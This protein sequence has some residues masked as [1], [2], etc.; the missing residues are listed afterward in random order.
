[1]KLNEQQLQVVNS[2]A[3]RIVCIA[4]AGA[5][6][7]ATL[8]QRIDRLISDGANPESMLILTFTNAAARE[9]TERFKKN[10]PD[11]TSIPEFRT[12]HAFCYSLLVRD[13]DIRHYMGY[14]DI[15]NIAVEEDIR[16]IWT[17]VHTTCNIRLS[18]KKLYGKREALPPKEQ[19][20]YDVF[21]KAYKKQLC[22][23]NLITF[24]ILCY[25]VGQLFVDDIDLVQGYKQKY[26]YVY[27][28]ESQDTDTAQFA[29]VMSFKDAQLFV[30]GD[31]QQMLYRFRG[32]TNDIIKSL[33]EDNTWELI[34]LPRNYRST[35]PIVDFSNKIFAKKWEG[36]PY[37]LAG[38][39]DKDGVPINFCN[40]FPNRSDRLMKVALEMQQKVNEGKSV[41]I[42]CRTNAK[43]TE[44]RTMF[45]D[46]GVPVKGKADNSE[47]V[48]L[49]KSVLD[50][51]YCV[52]WIA[53]MLPNEEYARYLRFST[54]DPSVNE[55]QKFLQM[56]GTKYVR[57]LDKLYHCRS[58]LSDNLLP[59]ELIRGML[60]Y[61]KL[62]IEL[63]PEKLISASLQECMD[64][65]VDKVEASVDKGIY[66]GTIHS[67]KGLEYDI[68][69]VVDVDGDSFNTMKNEDEMACFY[70]A[71]T[72]AKEELYLWYDTT[73][74]DELLQELSAEMHEEVVSGTYY[75][76]KN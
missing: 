72:R 37:Y 61:L 10:H 47:L 28:D 38:Q 70:V 60:R 52:K 14:S 13:T 29:F 48:G 71:C 41:A 7:T 42:L 69:H 74:D 30:C 27:Q 6:K 63:N 25:D 9:L 22:A 50:S 5:G 15:P 17:I 16:R 32:C 62:D 12:F 23:E 18:D 26:K 24:D 20:E 35:K 34:K 51:E 55:E 39:T 76:G 8:L 43:V 11:S 65:I 57:L 73:S 53:G 68:V 75:W 31:P 66:V 33:A 3:D 46:I 44:V 49:L 19:F 21:W 36:S 64:Y 59:M 4:S 54:L 2:N 45:M 1:M 58:L 56:F 67:V 40:S